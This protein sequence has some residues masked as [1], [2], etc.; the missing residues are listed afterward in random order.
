MKMPPC[1]Q[2]LAWALVLAQPWCSGLAADA[3]TG[4]IVRTTLGSVQGTRGEV[5]SFKGIPYAAPP[6]GPLRWRPP[7]PP[8]PWAEVRDATHFR[9]DCMQMPYVIPT[10]QQA[11]E[12]CLTV[13][14]WTPDPGAGAHR[15]VMV[16]IYGGAFIG[17]S[18]AYPLYDGAKLA[19]HGVVVVGF[20]YRVGIFGFLAHPMLSAE[21]PQHASG[22][23]GLLDQIAALQWVRANIAVFGGDAERVTVFGESA[24]AVSI[25]VLMTSPLARGL[26]A[27]AILHSPA[28]PPLASLAAAEKSGAKLGSDLAVLRGLSAAATAGPQ[29]RLLPARRA[30]DHGDG[31]SR[32][33]RRW[34]RGAGA[35]AHR[36]S[37]RRRGCGTDY[38]RHCRRRR[39]H[40]QRCADALPLTSIGSGV[41]SVRWRT[42]SSSSTRR[43]PTRPLPPRP[44]RS[45]G[46]AFFGES[47][48]LIA[49]A[50]SQRQP[51]TFAYLFSRSVAGRPQLATHS[52]MLPFLFGSLDKPSFIPHPP[53]D[54]T[55]L[56]AVGNAAG[57]LDALRRQ[58]RS[59]RA[60][61]AALARI[62][63]GDRSVP[64]IRDGDPGRR[65]V[66]PG[67]TRHA[68][69]LL[70]RRSVGGELGAARILAARVA[71]HADSIG[72]HWL[73]QP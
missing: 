22:N 4:P 71:H 30:P 19:S 44:L 38:R 33:D 55:D 61:A 56:A 62:L 54:R 66:P 69:D 57:S 58:R 26:F 51:Q 8:A 34:L 67:A 43:P 32:P 35:T 31:V 1:A 49:R 64:G 60:G 52:E 59:Q 12:D 40:V 41:R 11:S 39:P 23:Y 6:V 73:R 13:S 16:F 21:S 63:G 24:G 3:V 5:L 9:D 68:R 17:G 45:L 18:A 47:A 46:D 36:A 29:R 14:V 65:R 7:Q 48:R 10:G 27:H 20:N 28:V 53:P 42:N 37:E 72:F 25:A 2:Y 70:R 50:I 15:P